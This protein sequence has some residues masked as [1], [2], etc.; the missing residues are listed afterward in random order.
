MDSFFASVEIASRPYYKNLP[1]AVGENANSRGVIL[2]SSYKAREY[3]IRSGMPTYQAIQK[4]PSLIMINPDMGKY[5]YVSDILYDMIKKIVWNVKR[6]SIDEFFFFTSTKDE[7]ISKSILIKDL[8]KKNLKIT[9]SFGISD[10]IIVAKMASDEFK[11]D[12]L[13]VVDDSLIYIR[14]REV[15][16]VPGIGR[17][18]E[19]KLNSIGVYY[20]KQIDRIPFSVL[21]KIFKHRAYFLK[22]ISTLLTKKLEPLDGGVDKSI[23][24]THTFSEDTR[25]MEKLLSYLSIITENIERLMDEKF[26]EGSII[27]LVIRYS[28]FTTFTKQKKLGRYIYR[29]DDIFLEVSKMIKTMNLLLPVRLLGISVKGLR[30]RG[31]CGNIFLSDGYSQKLEESIKNI[32]I[33]F[34]D[35]AIMKLRDLYTNDRS[36]KNRRITYL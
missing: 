30:Q 6:Y 14:E 15:G 2:S 27:K 21:K 28:D 3:G 26:F 32:K 11:P 23:G 35:R 19:K 36:F 29:G 31:L 18:T 20:V 33:R 9:A 16:K 25:N 1:V 8:I 12:G 7:A 22:E 5:I 13:F 24:Q 10:N 34:G 17:K 4:C